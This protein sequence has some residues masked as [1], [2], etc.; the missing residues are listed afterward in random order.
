MTDFFT[1]YHHLFNVFLI[2]SGYAL[3]Q[4]V[5]MRA[6]VF[7]VATAGLASIGAYGAAI[8]TTSYGWPYPLALLAGTLLG[9]VAVLGAFALLNLVGISESAGVAMAMFVLH[10]AT[11]TVLSAWCL[12]WA[13]RNNW[14]VLRDNMSTPYPSGYSP[15]MAM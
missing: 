4:W 10:V 14:A 2:G 7:S 5:V 12:V 8:L 3:S 1:T 6:G 15:G 13:A 11:L 9:T